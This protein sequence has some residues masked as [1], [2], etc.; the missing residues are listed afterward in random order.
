MGAPVSWFEIAT[1][2]P[3]GVKAFYG[4][5]FGWTFD[6][7]MPGYT[8]ISTGDGQQ[9]GGGVFATN[10][11]L[12]N[13]SVFCVQVSDVAA[14]CVQ[15]EKLG[16]KILVQPESTPDGLVYAHILDHE[17]QQLGVFCP[18]AAA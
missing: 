4:D 14:T 7:A 12:P 16:G 5:L 10:G 3:E 2:D 11:D 6:E 1:T 9:I 15:A 17:G 8:I 13:Y 18:P